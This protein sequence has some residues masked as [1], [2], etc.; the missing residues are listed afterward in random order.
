MPLRLK[1]KAKAKL[2]SKDLWIKASVVLGLAVVVFLMLYHLGSIMPGISSGEQSLY[3]LKLGWHGI[4]HNPLN[5]PIN[6]LYSIIFKFGSPVGHTLLRLPAALTGG[7]TI[8]A[9]Y[10]LLQLWYGPRTA[11]FGSILFASSAWTLHV[12]RLAD[13]NIENLAAITFF[14][15]SSAILQK[16]LESRYVYWL[17]N[18][19]WSLLLYVPGMVF[20]IGYNIYRQR[21]EIGFGMKIQKGFLAKIAYLLSGLVWIPLLA[22]YFA[23]SSKNVLLWLGLPKHYPAPTHIVKEFGAVFYHIFIRGPIMPSLWLGR[24]PILDI[25]SVITALTGIYF[26]STH[27]KATR[28]HLL[29]VSFMVGAILIALGGAANLSMV[30]PI[31]YIFI[32]AGVAY[33]LSQWLS[34]FPENPIARSVGYILISLAVAASVIYNVRSYFVAWPHNSDSISVFDVKDKD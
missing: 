7:L 32:A 5:L 33:L 8:I 6:V 3:S 4:Y 27:I 10:I 17:I 1:P 21:E 28:T 14:L 16:R 31:V 29:F 9:F 12:S 23:E 19:A 2:D 20:L 25:F 34:I 24:A 15:L 18:L 11:L 26:Y 22:H 30:I 13:Y